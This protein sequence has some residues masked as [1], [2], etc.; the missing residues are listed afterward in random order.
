M[1]KDPVHYIIYINSKST[2]GKLGAYTIF[3]INRAFVFNKYC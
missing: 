1:E 3:F 2:I